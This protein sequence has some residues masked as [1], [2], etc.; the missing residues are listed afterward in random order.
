MLVAEMGTVGHLMRVLASVPG[1]EMIAL[2][3]FT[4]LYI[5]SSSNSFTQE[6]AN[7]DGLI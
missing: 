4:K 5:I 1:W 2:K 3:V 6:C 7:L